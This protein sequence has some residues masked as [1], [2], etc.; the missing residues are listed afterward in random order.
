MNIKEIGRIGLFGGTFNPVHCGHLAAARA[1]QRALTLDRVIFI[2]SGHPPL[3][4]NSGLVDGEHRARMLDLAIADEPGFAVCRWEIAREGLSFTVDT[5]RLL[6]AELG[7]TVRLFFL[8]GSDCADRIGRWKGIDEIR[9]QLQ[10]AIIARNGDRLGALP[11]DYL[12]VA[13]PP[14]PISATLVR[15]TLAADGDAA[16]LL[17]NEV[18]AYIAAH[19]LYRAPTESS[20]PCPATA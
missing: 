4:G 17:H 13:M 19:H 1:A 20:S 2:P 16:T 12:S 18:Q 10:F 3:K 5:V 14:V 9:A 7:D 11:P 8:L 6:R 15:D